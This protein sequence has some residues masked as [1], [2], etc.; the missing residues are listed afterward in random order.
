MT[1]VGCTRQVMMP[2]VGQMPAESGSPIAASIVQVL[3]EPGPGM[4]PMAPAS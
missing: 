3:A 4:D 1:V 2:Y